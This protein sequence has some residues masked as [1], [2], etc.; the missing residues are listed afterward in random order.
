MLKEG[1]RGSV[2]W[3]L[4]PQFSGLAVS[5]LFAGSGISLEV[6]QSLALSLREHLSVSQKPDMKGLCGRAGWH[7]TRAS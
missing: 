2:V 4:G 1:R 5:S 7:Q 3:L 6:A